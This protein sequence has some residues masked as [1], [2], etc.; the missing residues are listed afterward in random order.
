MILQKWCY[1]HHLPWGDD[2]RK[3][4]HLWASFPCAL[5]PFMVGKA[6]HLSYL[7]SPSCAS[8]KWGKSNRANRTTS[9]FSARYKF[10]FTIELFLIF[11][12]LQNNLQP[13]TE[14][15][16][17]PILCLAYQF[18]LEQI[19]YWVCAFFPIIYWL[20]YQSIINC[21]PYTS[22]MEIGDRNS[23]VLWCWYELMTVVVYYFREV[24]FQFE[25][26]EVLLSFLP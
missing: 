11:Y 23:C 3:E 21:C 15:F 10:F 20:C 19:K 18:Y 26:F 7:Q 22:W 25:I 16:T 5:P 9:W 6:A 13:W 8:W 4:T 17:F 2:Y 24:T 12:V 1:L 14:K